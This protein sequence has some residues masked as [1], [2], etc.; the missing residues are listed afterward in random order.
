VKTLRPRKLNK[1]DL[2][3][4]IAPASAVADT[5]KVEKAVRYLESLG[6]RVAVGKNV[7]NVHGYLAGTDDERLADLHAMFSNNRVKAILALRGGYGT[8][9]LLPRVNYTLIARN[10]RILCGFSDMTALQL[11]LWKHCRLVTFHGPMAAVDFANDLDPFTE[12]MFW[13]TITSSAKPDAIQCSLESSANVSRQRSARGRLLGGNLSLVVSLLGTQHQPTFRNALLFL[14]EVTEE[15]YRI[16]RM[17]THLSNAAVLAQVNG[18]LLGQ[19]TD[20]KPADPTK[21]SQTTDQVLDD[22]VARF[23]KPTLRNLPFGHTAKKMTIPIGVR[24]ELDAKKQTLRLTEAA[25]LD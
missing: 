16:D 15:P 18:L 3:G 19:F 14:E 10:P 17:M 23:K 12:E 21:P 6:Y 7:G 25:V 4:L 22:I 5:T 8:L 9:R 2:I 13:R 20:C 24:A 11:A 1:G